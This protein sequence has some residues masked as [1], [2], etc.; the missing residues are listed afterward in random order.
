MRYNQVRVSRE[1][2]L[3]CLLRIVTNEFGIV[4]GEALLENRILDEHVS[5]KLATVC[6]N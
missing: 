4:R 6:S 5:L 2:R 3:L 1:S